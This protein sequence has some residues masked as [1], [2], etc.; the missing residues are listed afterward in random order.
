M[1]VAIAHK[2]FSASKLAKNTWRP[3]ERNFS[4]LVDKN[5][6]TS[7]VLITLHKEM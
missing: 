3:E 4:R 6:F 1:F 7:I 2:G 5:F